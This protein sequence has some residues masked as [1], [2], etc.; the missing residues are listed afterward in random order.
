MSEAVLSLGVV[1]LSNTRGDD[2]RS[3]A[4]KRKL[5]CLLSLVDPLH[6]KFIDPRVIKRYLK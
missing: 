4:N 3:K 1:C 5:L 2:M 6:D